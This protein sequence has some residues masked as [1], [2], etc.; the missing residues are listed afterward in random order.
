M[1]EVSLQKS[2]PYSGRMCR[3]LRRRSDYCHRVAIFVQRFPKA[4]KRAHAPSWWQS[5]SKRNQALIYMNISLAAL[6]ALAHRLQNLAACFIQNGRRGS[7]IGQTL[8][9]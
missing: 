7:E 5:S 8:G 6:G 1:G 2:F 9:N 4:G 3:L